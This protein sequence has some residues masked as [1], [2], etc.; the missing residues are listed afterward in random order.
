MHRLIYWLIDCFTPHSENSDTNFPTS[1][2]IPELYAA[3]RDLLTLIFRKYAPFIEQTAISLGC[4][5]AIFIVL[6]ADAAVLPLS[7][8][9]NLGSCSPYAFF[10]LS[11]LTS[12]WRHFTT[13]VHPAAF[14]VGVNI[15]SMARLTC[16]TLYATYRRPALSTHT[17]DAS[18][19]GCRSCS[20]NED[21]S[22]ALYN[23]KGPFTHLRLTTTD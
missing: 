13:K 19:L 7:T 22:F 12:G 4:R 5:Q 15:S 1:T 14:L 2:F 17:R 10:R 20:A 3:G 11:E 21:T 23:N 9:S 18:A 8:A 6:N 16:L